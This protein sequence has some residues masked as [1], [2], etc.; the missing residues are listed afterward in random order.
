MKAYATVA[1]SRNRVESR[2]GVLS[3]RQGSLLR[4]RGSLSSR[5]GSLL[6]RRGSLLSR[7]GS[8]SSR[9]G[10]LSGRQGSLS[11][12][13]GLLSSRQGSLSRQ[14][15][16]VRRERKRCLVGRIGLL[17]DPGS[18]QGF[19]VQ[20]YLLTACSSLFSGTAQPFPVPLRRQG[21]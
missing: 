9:R 13:L 15:D 8:L 5:Q 11:S 14:H 4:R 10:S 6:R 21:G 7:Q 3:S 19:F 1:A 20:L 18:W 12:H 2:Q 16:A 17:N